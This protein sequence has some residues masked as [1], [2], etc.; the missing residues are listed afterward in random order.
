[1]AAPLDFGGV[2]FYRGGQHL[3][4]GLV[5]NGVGIA[6]LERIVRLATEVRGLYCGRF[7]AA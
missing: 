7:G 4:Q 3:L 2:N 6:A 5:G 1:M